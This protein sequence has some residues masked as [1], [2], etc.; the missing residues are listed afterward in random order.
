MRAPIALS[1]TKLLSLAQCRRKLWLETYSPELVDE[2]SAEKSALLATGNRVG[3]LA[4]KLYGKGGGHLVSFERGLRAAIDSTRALIAA[5]GREPIFEATFD[6]DG[7][8]ARIDVLDRSEPQPKLI[9]VKS[10]AHV[11]EHYLD[12]C[13]V[14]AWAL[15][16]N[17]LAPRQVVVATL[18]TQWVYQGDGVYDGLLVEHDVTDEVRERLT[19]VPG[20]VRDARATLADLDEPA[21][22]VGVHCGAPYGCEFYAHC[23]PPAGQYS[24]LGLGGS[25]ETLFEL[26]HCGLPRSARRAGGRAQERHAAAHLAAV[27]ARARVRRRRA[28]RRWRASCRSRATTWT[29]RRSARPCRCSPARGRSRRCRSNGRVTSR[30]SPERFEHAEFLQLAPEPP[31]RELAERL[32]ATLGTNGPI[33]VYTPY[34]RRC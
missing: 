22:A 20:W 25:K 18:D 30:R 24:V 2:P 19:E 13:A 29:S 27:A 4:R 32:L 21:V 14:Q 26:M 12:D 7:V 15:A 1:K 23:A 10:S 6:H 28:A 11:K 9:E 17:G 3:E 31:I 8:S 33:V 34:E 5:G 16:E